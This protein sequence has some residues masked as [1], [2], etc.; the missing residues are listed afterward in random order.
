MDNQEELSKVKKNFL[1]SKIK[2][3]LLYKGQ[4]SKGEFLEIIYE[5]LNDNDNIKYI[6]K[7]ISYYSKNSINNEMR[8]N[9]FDF[10]IELNYYFN[11]YIFN[12]Y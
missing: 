1:K 6:I 9:C 10:F 2:N 7:I 12:W 4:E 5:N 11:L 3:I 8:I